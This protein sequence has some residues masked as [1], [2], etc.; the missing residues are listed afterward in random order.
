MGVLLLH[1]LMGIFETQDILYLDVKI[2]DVRYAQDFPYVNIFIQQLLAKENLT[3][4]IHQKKKNIDCK[5]NNL[6]IYLHVKIVVS[7][8]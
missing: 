3:F 7:S 2:Q 1:L 5:S 8:M 6:I 4:L